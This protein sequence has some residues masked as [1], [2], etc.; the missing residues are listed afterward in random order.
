MGIILF[1]V[2]VTTAIMLAVVS[3]GVIRQHRMDVQTQR[4]ATLM[5][6]LEIA[7]AELAERMRAIGYAAD[8]AVE[9]WSE[10]FAFALDPDN[11]AATPEEN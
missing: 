7:F 4:W 1:V 2:A 3:P 10:A 8:V 5:P 6:R 11:L 9:R